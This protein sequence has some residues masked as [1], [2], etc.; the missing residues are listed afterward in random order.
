M[1]TAT[2]VANHDPRI[3]VIVISQPGDYTTRVSERPIVA[4]AA[5][6]DGVEPRF[7]GDFV[8]FRDEVHIRYPNGA[9][10]SDEAGFGSENLADVL[11]PFLE[12]EGGDDNEPDIRLGGLDLFDPSE[13]AALLVQFRE[14]L[15]DELRDEIDRAAIAEVL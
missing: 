4:W 14:H 3:T 13:R 10:W 5:S 6:T 11:R 1:T 9:L 7:P 15:T 8:R 12:A 2:V